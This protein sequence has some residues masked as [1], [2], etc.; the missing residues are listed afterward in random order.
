MFYLLLPKRDLQLK[1]L[2]TLPNITARG[3]RAL[4]KLSPRSGLC[5]LF[6]MGFSGMTVHSSTAGIQN[7]KSRLLLVWFWPGTNLCP[8][9]CGIKPETLSLGFFISASAAP[10]PG[11]MSPGIWKKAAGLPGPMPH[12]ISYCRCARPMSRLTQWW[13]SENSLESSKK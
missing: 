3:D 11:R 6:L 5:P 7:T 12:T 1:N 2:N 9:M 4:Q 10:E 8:W 13:K